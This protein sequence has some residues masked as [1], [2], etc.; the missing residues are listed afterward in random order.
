LYLGATTAT[1]ASSGQVSGQLS[2]QQT[3]N[4]ARSGQTTS[5]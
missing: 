4:T 1:A 5:S 2:G 3:G